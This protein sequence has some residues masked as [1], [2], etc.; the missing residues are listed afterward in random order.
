MEAVGSSEIL[1]NFSQTTRYHIPEDSIQ[2]IAL[3]ANIYRTERKQI[4][5]FLRNI[6]NLFVRGDTRVF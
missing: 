3:L 2:H 4:H 6:D 5:V 1:V